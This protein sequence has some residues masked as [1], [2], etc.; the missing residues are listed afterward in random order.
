MEACIEFTESNYYY[1]FLC[2]AS[3]HANNLKAT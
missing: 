2:Y 1:N 3:R